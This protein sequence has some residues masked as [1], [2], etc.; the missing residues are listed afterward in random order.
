MTTDAEIEELRRIVGVVMEAAV[1]Y[2]GISFL[3]DRQCCPDTFRRVQ[4]AAMLAVAQA[5]VEAVGHTHTDGR[6]R[7]RCTDRWCE[8]LAAAEAL[9]TRLQ[10]GQVK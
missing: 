4:Q 5:R 3:P 8:R 6:R 1:C 9:V 10:E 2:H 7:Q